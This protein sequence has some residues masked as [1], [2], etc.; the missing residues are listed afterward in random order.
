MIGYL[1]VECMI[2]DVQSLKSKR[3][4]VKQTVHS[5]Q[6][7]Y[8]VSITEIDYHDIWQRTAFGIATVSTQKVMAE[9]ILQDVLAQIEG[10][11]D[12]EVTIIE[13]EWL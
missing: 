4:V 13:Y 3:S 1:Y 11:T 7:R 8:N 5:I 9:K 2:Y 10:R 12:L 6:N